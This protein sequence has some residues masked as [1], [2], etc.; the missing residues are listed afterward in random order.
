MVLFAHILATGAVAT[1]A[2]LFVNEALHCFGQGN[3][4]CAHGASLA[5]LANFAKIGG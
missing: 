4:H 3:I 5:I 1:L 2:D